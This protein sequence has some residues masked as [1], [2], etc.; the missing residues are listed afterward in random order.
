MPK[1]EQTAAVPCACRKEDTLLRRKV[2]FCM[3]PPITS[4]VAKGL[5][6]VAYS[7]NV[8]LPGWLLSRLD[9]V[10]V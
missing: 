5:Q 6:Y 10:L 7:H 2:S 1:G 3:T 8:A 4:T 9:N